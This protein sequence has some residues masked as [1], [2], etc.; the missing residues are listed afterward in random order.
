M[1]SALD[2]VDVVGVAV[3]VFVDSVIVLQSHFDVDS[4]ALTVEVNHLGIDGLFVFVE[5]GDELTDSALVVE[6]LA[7]RLDLLGGTLIGEGDMD[8]AVEKSKLTQT[9]LKSIPVVNGLAENGAVGLEGHFGSTLGGIADNFELRG[10]LAT[11]ETDGVNLAV[12]ADL[13]IHPV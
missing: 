8:S 5:Q 6:V 11:L 3:D 13:D 12:T 4:V 1:G 7:L 9:F 10:G 2:S